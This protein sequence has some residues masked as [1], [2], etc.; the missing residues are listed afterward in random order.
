MSM[1]RNHQG[2]TTTAAVAAFLLVQHGAADD[3]CTLATGPTQSIIGANDNVAKDIGE[4][5]D[6]PA[7]GVHEVALGASVTRGQELTADAT[8]RAVP[9]APG[10]GVNHY[11]FGF[12]LQSGVV[13][14]RI[15][16]Q[17]ARGLK[18]G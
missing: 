11:Y 13:G 16:Y 1:T 7:F 10:A 4:I 5:V 17:V 2:F 8:S 15:R 3:S 18:Q 14:D 6:T 12:A 9:C